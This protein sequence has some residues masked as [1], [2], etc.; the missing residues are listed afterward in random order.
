MLVIKEIE[1]DAKYI[2]KKSRS[3]FLYSTLFLP[4]EK[5]E[6]LRVLYAF[7][8][9]SD[10]ITD[11]AAY[12]IDEKRRLL[13]EWKENLISA[14]EF[15][16]SK[17]IILNRLAQVIQVFKIPVEYF[18]EFLKGMEMDLVQNYYETFSELKQYCY[19]VASTVGL[20]IIEVLGYKN[21][22]VKKYAEHLGIALQLTNILRDVKEDMQNKRI[23]FPIED[24]KKFDYTPDELNRNVYNEC[25]CSLMKYECNRANEYFDLARSFL[26]QEDRKS[27]F[28]ARIIEKIYRSILQK[29]EKNNYNI[30]EYQA[31]VSRFRKFYYAFGVYVKYNL[32]IR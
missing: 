5:S 25:F 27:M 29:I 17:S 7:F 11:S 16:N 31:R 10:D 26:P 30:F 1:A 21:P 20:T 2:T 15:N 24:L 14:I 22:L 4:R 32:L 12:S 18:I 13:S 28:M 8:R 23:Y 3:N 6:A 9:Y 19:R